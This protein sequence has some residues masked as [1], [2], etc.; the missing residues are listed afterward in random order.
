M[1]HPAQR[2]PCEVRPFLN[3]SPSLRLAPAS[4]TH[5]P[6]QAA[7]ASAAET[8]NVVDVLKERGLVD[9]IT[10]EAA[11]RAAAEQGSLKVYCG[12]DPTAD[13]LHLVRTHFA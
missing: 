2:C 13:S 1:S 11:L 6:P 7:A 9:A 10:N 4:A 8:R 3:S 12:F 5:Q